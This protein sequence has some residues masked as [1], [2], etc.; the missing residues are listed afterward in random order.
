M[1][2]PSALG[3]RAAPLGPWDARLP[4]LP[5]PLVLVVLVVL[6]L[7]L[8]LLGGAL[9]ALLT[10]LVRVRGGVGGRVVRPKAR[11]NIRA[12]TGFGVRVRDA[13]LG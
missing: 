12:L 9:L 1:E 13:G 3:T 4:V 8:L 11:V 2:V 5:L 6:L 10:H 7:P